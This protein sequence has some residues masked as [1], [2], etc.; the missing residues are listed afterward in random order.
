MIVELARAIRDGEFTGVGTLSPLPLAALLL[1]RRTHAPSGRH[2]AFFKHDV[3]L[4]GGTKEFFDFA[5]RGDLD[6]FFLSGAQVAANGDINLSVIG[7]NHDRPRV[8]LPGGAGSAMLYECA[9][10]VVLFSMRHDV[11]T[12][13]K[14]VDFVTARG[15]SARQLDRLVTPL[16]TFVFEEGRFVLDAIRSDVTIEEVRAQTGF[17]VASPRRAPPEIDDNTRA[18][19]AGP[20]RAEVAAVYPA[21]SAT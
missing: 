10:R 11:R 7:A 12:L 18:L 6:L 17:P 19:I 21:F 15:T 9:R 2:F 20:V 4:S 14:G 1:A 3:A 16:A 5:Q 8:R 13:V